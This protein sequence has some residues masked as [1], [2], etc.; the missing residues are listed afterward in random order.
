MKKPQCQLIPSAGPRMGDQ[1]KKLRVPISVPVRGGINSLSVAEG[2][3]PWHDLIPPVP[4]SV[5]LP[6]GP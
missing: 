5:P 3:S 4:G 6:R 2:R 1:P